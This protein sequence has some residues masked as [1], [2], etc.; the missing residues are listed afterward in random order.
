MAHWNGG[1]IETTKGREYIKQLVREKKPQVTWISPECGP[2]SPMQRLNQKTEQQRK[3]L[4]DK[5]N[6]AQ[7]QYEGALEIAR[8]VHDH[9]GVFVIELSERCEAWNLKVFHEFQKQLQNVHGHM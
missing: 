8:F 5:R 9:G 4:E 6:H 1:D 7:K 3:N 2:Y